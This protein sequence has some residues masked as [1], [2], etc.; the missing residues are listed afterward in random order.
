LF[1]NP[2]VLWERN[3]RLWLCVPGYTFIYRCLRITA[4]PNSWTARHE[5]RV[6]QINS[7]DH[8]EYTLSARDATVVSLAANNGADR[9]QNYLYFCIWVK[10]YIT[11]LLKSFIFLLNNPEIP[12]S[13]NILGSEFT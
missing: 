9:K 7:S 10:T 1:P 13:S 3:A 11:E 8:I 5:A 4:D 12:W 2:D 6:P